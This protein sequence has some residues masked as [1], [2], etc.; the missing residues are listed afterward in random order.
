VTLQLLWLE[1]KE[2]QPDGYQHGQFYE[3]Y[4]YW[5][6]K[7]DVV[8]R[9][10]HRAG[11]KMFVDYAG[12]TVPV[13]DP[14][15]REKRE[16]Q[17]F[18]AVLGASSY[19]YT[20]VS[21]S[22]DLSSWIGVHCRALEFF[23]G[24]PEIIVPDNRKAGVKHSSHYEPDLNP[25]YQEMAGHYGVAVIPA[26]PR[27]ARDKAKAEVGV[28]V[29]ERW[30]LARL[31]NRTFFGLGELNRAIREGGLSAVPLRGRG[32]AG[33]EAAAAQTLRVRPVE[34]AK[35]NID[36]HIQ[37][38]RNLYSVPHSLTRREVD[39]RITAGTVEV[40]HKGRRVASHPRVEGKGIHVTDPAHMP[41]AHR[42]HLEWTPSR[43]VGWADT[44]GPHTAELFKAI[45]ESRVHPEQG[46]R[47]S[48]GIMRPLR[49]YPSERMEAA[50][51]RTL[52]FNALSCR[53]VNSILAKGLDE[54]PIEQRP[55]K[56]PLNHANVRGADYRPARSYTR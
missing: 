43:L 26:R 48:L 18:V 40:L 22:Q 27:K 52:A 38:E 2:N 49:H 42:K 5:R 21:W 35:V 34:E 31:R 24:V 41:S 15:T 20:E 55:E 13:I 47:S 4:R 25:T 19:T 44:I 3:R 16:A 10:V 50:A 14:V 56:T 46:Y 9:Q 1:Y 30:I 29:L 11:E 36:Y 23:G 53:S 28:Q 17:I 33:P 8:M 12:Q 39:V 37:V 54:Q 32:Q 51:R 6:G 7:L 45:L